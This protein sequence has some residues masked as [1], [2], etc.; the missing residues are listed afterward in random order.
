MAIIGAGAGGIAMAIRLRQAGFSDVTIFEK[1]DGFG[2][3][4]RDNTYPGCACDAPSHLYSFSFAPNPD[5]SRKFAAQPEILA[6]MERVARDNGLGPLARFG[7]EVTS[8]RRDDD[9]DDWELT[10]GDGTLERYD[11]VVAAMG[12]LNR[13]AWPTIEGLDGFGGTTFH[14]AR[15]DHEHDLRGERV[16]VIGNGASAVQFVPE[17]V[18]RLRPPHV[19]P[20]QR[21][22]GRAEA[23]S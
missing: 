2:G 19:V 18:K 1:S 13:P 4:W 15:W 7:V 17:V 23:R 20:A 14:S 10:L 16:A 12:Q 21:Q 5:W 11:V 22:L 3:T 6:Y 9:R 8:I